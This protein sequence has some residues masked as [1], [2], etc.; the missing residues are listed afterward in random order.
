MVGVE[1]LPTVTVVPGG[2]ELL[3]LTLLGLELGDPGVTVGPIAA[4][5]ALGFPGV[6]VGEPKAGP[7][8]GLPLGDPG[9]TVGP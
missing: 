6:T 9:V 5:A 2:S 4:G 7:F 8:V 3:A 1:L